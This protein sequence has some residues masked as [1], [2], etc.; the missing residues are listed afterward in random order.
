MNYRHHY[1][2]GN[3]ADVLKHAVLVQLVRGL[4]RKEKGFLYVDTHAGRGRYDLLAAAQGETLARKAEWPDGI[5][6]VWAEQRTRATSTALTELVEI[7]RD[8]DRAERAPGG[9]AGEASAPRHYPGSPR[10]VRALLRP[11]DRMAL[12]EKHPEEVA[13]L[14]AEFSHERRVSVQALDGYTGVRAT[15]PPP[16]RRALVLIDPPFEAQDEFARVVGALREGLRRMPAATFAVWYPLTERARVEAFLDELARLRPPPCGTVEL[17]V[18]GP[19]SALKMKGCGVAVVN[20]PWQVAETMDALAAELAGILAQ[21]PGGD[22]GW[23]WIV[24]E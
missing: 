24:P 16:E 15:L 11:Q 21:E 22:G 9:E 6:R 13:A 12:F 20:P 19:A 8:F 10:V 4:Q 2:A 18:A 5:G 3:F 7:V 14:E 23:R 17:T 1:H